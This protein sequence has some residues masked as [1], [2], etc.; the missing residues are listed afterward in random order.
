MAK[1]NVTAANAMFEFN[2]PLATTTARS[3]HV[4]P[5]GVVT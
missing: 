5:G 2:Y 1:Q 4:E 3:V